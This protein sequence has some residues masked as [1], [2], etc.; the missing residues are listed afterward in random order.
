MDGISNHKVSK[1][2][3]EMARDEVVFIA[4]NRPIVSGNR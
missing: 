4:H 2:T 1:I 3:A